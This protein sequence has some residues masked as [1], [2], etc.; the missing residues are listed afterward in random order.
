MIKGPE[1]IS[2]YLQSSWFTTK[3]LFVFITHE[4]FTTVLAN[5]GLRA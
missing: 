5:Q 3:Q 4:G 2:Q 1:G